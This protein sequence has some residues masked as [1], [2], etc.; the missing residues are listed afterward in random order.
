[1][2]GLRGD[3][4]SLEAARQRIDHDI[5]YIDNWSIWFDLKILFMSVKV[6]FGS[7]NAF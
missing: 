1:V 3:T 4:T 5:Y 7:K 2:N 6:M